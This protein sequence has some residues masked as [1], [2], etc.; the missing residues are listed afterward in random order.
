M[1][2]TRLALL[3]LG[4]SLA[5]ALPAAAQIR[6]GTVEISPFYGYLWGG[7]FAEGTNDLF[8]YRVDVDDDATYGGRL[9]FNITSLFQIEFQ[10]SRTETA[11]IA[12]DDEIFGPEPVRLGGLDIDYYMGYAT[13]NFGH[14]RFVPY[15]TVGAGVASLDPDV[16]DVSASSDTRFTASLGGGLKVFVTPHFGFRFDGRGYS[17]Y[18]GDNNRCQ[19]CCDDSFYYCSDQ[20]WLTNG[21]ASGG[22]IIAF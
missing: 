12:E 15:V 9:G 22:L 16:P 13:F 20:N 2:R 5:A 14:S 18:L 17:T 21:E 8:P 10:Y 4:A 19:G 7:S 1:N 11:F 6:Q 3:V